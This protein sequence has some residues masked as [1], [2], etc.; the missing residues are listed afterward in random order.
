MTAAAQT[1]LTRDFTV[2]VFVIWGGRLLLHPHPKIGKLLPPGGHVEPGELPDEA[3][4]RETLEETGLRVRLLGRRG[5][6]DDGVLPL[7]RPHG[8]QLEDIRPDHQHIDLIY[9]AEPEPGQDIRPLEP[10][11]WYAADQLGAAPDEIRQWAAIA[12]ASGLEDDPLRRVLW[13]SNFDPWESLHSALMVSGERADQLLAHVAQT[14]RTYWT[15]IAR[16]CGCE[17]P[18]A[19]GTEL[20]DDL[21][22][23]MH[24]ELRAVGALSD[25]DRARRLNYSGRDLSVAE[26]VRLS[27]RHS[28]WHAGQVRA[29]R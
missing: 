14:K 20:R 2:A 25:V 17:A 13:E 29:T 5:P 18:P 6:A 15:L 27:A 4:V 9:F 1:T 22:A 12:L 28:V 7:V 16:A 19:P 11:A 10:F 8:V 23:L 21:R 26:L 3:A 24:Y